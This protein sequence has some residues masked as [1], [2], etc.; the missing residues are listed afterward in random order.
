MPPPVAIETILDKAAE[1][2][3]A[4]VAIDFYDRTLTFRRVA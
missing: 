4:K 3:P 2:W 1:I